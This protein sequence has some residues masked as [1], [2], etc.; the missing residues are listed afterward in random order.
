MRSRSNST[1]SFSFSDLSASPSEASISDGSY[2]NGQ[3]ANIKVVGSI[4]GGH[5]GL[6][7]GKKY[8]VDSVGVLTTSKESLADYFPHKYVGVAASSDSIIVKG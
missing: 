8:Y 2:T 3:T 4:S 7:T 5:T 1:R 6:T